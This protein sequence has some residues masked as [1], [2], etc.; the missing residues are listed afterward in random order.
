MKTP[1]DKRVVSISV[2]TIVAVVLAAF[3]IGMRS[4][5]VL[6]DVE[7]L[8]EKQEVCS[9]MWIAQE[10]INDRLTTTTELFKRDVGHILEAIKRIEDNI[11]TTSR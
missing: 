10:K 5:T 7:I 1:V 2:A 3:T 11:D 9:Q 8:K 6:G 4:Q